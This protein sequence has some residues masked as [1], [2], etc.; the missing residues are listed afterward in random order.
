VILA[1]APAVDLCLGFANTRFWRGQDPPTETLNAPADLLDW[2]EKQAGWPASALAPVRKN[3]GDAARLLAEA[4][5]L[6]EAIYRLFAAFADGTAAAPADLDLVN[7]ALAAAPA[8]QQ[9]VERERGYGWAIAEAAGAL[10]VLLAPVL[11]STADLLIAAG[12]RRVRR[13]AND[14]CL[15]LFVDRSKGGT[16]RWCDMSACGNRA[17]S[18]R[19]YLKSKQ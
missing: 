7:R 5:G 4:I 3:P 10:P 14:R 15:W 18:R 1:F 16:R 8:R 19:H 17:K 6:R 13:C 9:L 11:W 12:E 2:L